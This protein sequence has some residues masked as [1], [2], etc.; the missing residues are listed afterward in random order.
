[1]NAILPAALQG[2]SRHVN[3]PRALITEFDTTKRATFN[4]DYNHAFNA[5]GYHTLK[6]GFG[7]Q[8]T[9]NDIN[10]VLSGRLRQHLLGPHLRVRRS[11]PGTRHATATTR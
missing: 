5:G 6:G 11:D 1:M 3:T 10:Y 2:P 4:V 8:R 7:F 9:M